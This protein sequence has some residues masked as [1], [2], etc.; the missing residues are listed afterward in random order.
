MSAVRL[1]VRA[2]WRGR[3]RSLVALA[4]IAGLAGAVSVGAVSGSRRVDTSFQ[5]LLDYTHEPNVDVFPTEADQ[6]LVARAARLPGVEVAA[7]FAV[8]AAAPEGPDF[9]PGRSSIAL[10]VPAMVGRERWRSR[11][12]QGREPDPR[13]PAQFVVNEAMRKAMGARIG[14]RIR[15]VSLTPEQTPAALEQG[16]D[17][18][19]PAGPSQVGTLVGVVRGAE[20]VSDAPDPA[21]WVTPAFYQRH[22]DRI[23]RL[24]GVA[25]RVDDEHLATIEEDARAVFGTDAVQLRQA[26]LVARIED[27]LDVQVIGLRVFALASALAGLVA[28]GQILVRQL[29][30]VAAQHRTRRALGMTTRQ[31]VAVGVGTALPVALAA[32]GLAAAGAVAGGPLTITGVAEIAEPDP[33]PWFDGPAVVPGAVAVTA[34]V[35]GLATAV[36]AWSA[37][38]SWLVAP[39]WPGQ[40]SLVARAASAGGLR[41]AV[42]MGARIALETG[43]G[44]SAV[45]VRPALAGA[46]VGVAGVVAAVTFGATVDHLFATPRLWGAQFDGVLEAGGNMESAERIAKQV[47]GRSEVAAV[48]VFRS[49]ELKL[50]AGGRN[51]TMETETVDARRGAMPPVLLEGRAP[52]G[53]DEVALGLGVLKSLQLRQGDTVRADGLAGPVM[54]R[55]VGSHVHPG[56][57]EVDRGVLLSPKGFEALV[58]FDAQVADARALAGVRI[59]FAPGVDVDAAIARLGDTFS[60][61]YRGKAPSN[62]DNLDEL[63]PLP[64]V[65]AAFLGALAATAALHALVSGTRSRR[66][67]LAVLRALGFVPGQVRGVVRWQALM[68]AAVGLLVGLPLGFAAARALWSRVAAGV[69]VLDESATPWLMLALTVVGTLVAAVVIAAGPGRAAARVRPADVLRA[70]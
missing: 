31:L 36:S 69:G 20:D 63:G 7:H 56:V 67:D 29:A 4:L 30:A 21:F 17:P 59:R 52:E 34:S 32:A 18:G 53:P 43:H 33:G 65:L 27:S 11:I 49:A 13:D 19:V 23:G 47:A 26:D 48:A 41:P 1:T 24:D 51:A 70:E 42:V 10:A 57:D 39:P 22:A 66:R 15:L 61:A 68:V 44:A 58:D 6:A 3:W 64:S 8:L 37:R 12:V 40:P 14:E 5:R 46:A 28:V 25:M 9:R 55:V 60:V 50:V 16:V 35:L 62:V 54:L 38:R 45:P 2:E